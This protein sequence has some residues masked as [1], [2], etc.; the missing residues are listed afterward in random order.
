MAISQSALLPKN[1]YAR[2]VWAE[3]CVTWDA[4]LS[5][6]ML[7][8]TGTAKEVIKVGYNSAEEVM[9]TAVGGRGSLYAL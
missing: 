3:Y 7:R 9:R 6:G 8:M 4:A 2:N 5:D 1:R